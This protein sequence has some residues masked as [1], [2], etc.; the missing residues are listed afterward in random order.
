MDIH[1]VSPSGEGAIRCMAGLE[2]IDEVDYI[3]AHGTS[4]PVGD[5][6]ELKAIKEFLEII[7]PQYLQQNL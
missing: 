6:T 7:F 4:T 1:L 2:G 3:N 5:I